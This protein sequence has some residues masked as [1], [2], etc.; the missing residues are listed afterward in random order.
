MKIQYYAIIVI[1][2]VLIFA[3][4]QTTFGYNPTLEDQLGNSSTTKLVHDGSLLILNQTSEK[5]TYKSGENITIIPEIINIGN[6][7]VNLYYL[8]PSLFLEIKNQ[9]GNLVW[10]QSATVGYIPEFSGMKVLKP[11]EKYGVKPW[12]TPTGPA[13]DPSPIVISVPGNYTAIS[14]ASFKFDPKP[15]DPNSDVYLWSR[16]L[17]ITVLPE[18][19]P[20]FPFAQVMLVFGIISAV[21]IYR[22]MK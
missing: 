15:N 8:E 16:P 10:P 14:V 19:A 11:G 2:F 5:W 1:S 9:D 21:V 18:N 3:L 6:K 13:Y 12:T 4:S 20:E 7:T 22:K 17:Q